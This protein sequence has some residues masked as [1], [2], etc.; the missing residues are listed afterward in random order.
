MIPPGLPPLA[1]RSAGA[2]LSPPTLTDSPSG[3]IG[4][5]SFADLLARLAL[6]AA[7]QSPTIPAA[8]ATEAVSVFDSLTS[9]ER[10]NERGL[11]DGAAP[12]NPTAPDP[13]GVGFEMPRK[14]AQ[15]PAE[16][17]SPAPDPA[18]DWPAKALSVTGSLAHGEDHRT[19]SAAPAPAAAPSRAARAPVGGTVP[20][21]PASA[22]VEPLRQFDAQKPVSAGRILRP[23]PQS[24][25]PSTTPAQ[26]SVQV[27]ESG[28]RL[29]VRV[30]KLSREQRES[31]HA[32]IVEIV[33]RHGFVGADILINGASR[34]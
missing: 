5:G 29:V 11:F 1:D 21:S 33:A 8:G 7:A 4:A 2:K 25:P 18:R 23:Q 15:L 16:N 22:T 20:A 24:P 9:A 10:F 27:T 14:A 28:L 31:L 34:A 12:L 26:V 32:E 3:D 30:E 13:F 6:A 17:G 19:V